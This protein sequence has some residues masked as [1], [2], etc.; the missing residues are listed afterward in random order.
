MPKVTQHLATEKEARDV[1]ER[2]RQSEWTQPSFGPHDTAVYRT[3]LG[4]L[5]PEFTWLE[6]GIVDTLWVGA[7]A[8][9]NRSC[10]ASEP[11]G[12]T[13]ASRGG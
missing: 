8:K 11:R 1:A 6:Q 12:E 3:A 10:N 7:D 13:P 2:A 5:G 4:V 9:R